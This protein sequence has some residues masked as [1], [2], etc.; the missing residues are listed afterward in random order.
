MITDLTLQDLL[1]SIHLGD[2]VW[3]EEEKLGYTVRAIS[4]NFIICTK[5]FNPKHTVLY[6]IIDT[7]KEIRGTENLIFC[8]GAE[9]DEQ[10]TSMLQRLV[11]GE[12][13]IS[14]RNFACI[15]ITKVKPLD[16][17]KEL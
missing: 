1:H 6:T 15:H 5:P 17:Q 11:S 10:V 16:K 13:E 3:F 14:H 4:D 12:T 8:A 9:T 2:K 7:V